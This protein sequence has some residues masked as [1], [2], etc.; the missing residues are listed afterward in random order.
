MPT[1]EYECQV[2]GAETEIFQSIK[3]QPKRKCPACGDP[4]GLRRKIGVGAGI[5]FR[6]S[7]FYQ[8]DYRSAEYK[9]RAEAEASPS[10]AKGDGAKSAEKTPAKKGDDGA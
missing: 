10:S 6:G 5:I 8:T 3:E 9:K 4:R 7:G 1:Y 2:C